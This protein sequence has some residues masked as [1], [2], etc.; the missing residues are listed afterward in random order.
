MRG[1]MMRRAIAAA[2]GITVLTWLAGCETDFIRR[3]AQNSAASFL[4]GVFGDA[5]NEAIAAE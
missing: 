5:I 2:V 1:W 4:T 3:N